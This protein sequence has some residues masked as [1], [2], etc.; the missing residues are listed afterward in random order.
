[1]G[2]SLSWIA[3]KG[4]SPHE[5]HTTMGAR[6]TGRREDFPESRLSAAQLPNGF[7]LVVFDREELAPAKLRQFSS[8]FDLLYGFVEEHVMYSSVAAWHRGEQL[9]SVVHDAQKDILHL[10]V[11]G[12]PPAN[13]AAI[14]D[15]L[16]AQ[17]LREDPQK[18]E[19]DYVFDIP[20]EL[21]KELTTYR[22]DHDIEGMG[23]GAF[24]ILEC[25]KKS[26]LWRWNPF[27]K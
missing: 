20:V 17:Q 1:M 16:I 23:P 14:R 6:S 25:I 22:Y 7:Y 18:P 12:S 4:H 8:K 24:E 21:A 13:F 10:E 19:V 26:E 11:N 15:R 9:W 5:V 27:R 2:F 3:I